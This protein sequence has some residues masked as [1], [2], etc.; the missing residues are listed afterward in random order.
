MNKLLNL[1]NIFFLVL[2]NNIEFPI[3]I[4]QFPIVV[5]HSL[6]CDSSLNI[7]K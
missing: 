5:I 4:I 1:K 7:Y 2:E 6:M 3:S